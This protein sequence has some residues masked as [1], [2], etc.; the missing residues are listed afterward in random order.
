MTNWCSPGAACSQYSS[1]YRWKCEV[2]VISLVHCCSKQTSSDIIK[3]LPKMAN[4]LMFLQFSGVSN[5]K[6]VDWM[7]S[8]G[9][10]Q[11]LWQKMIDSPGA[12]VEGVLMLRP[13][14]GK[15]RL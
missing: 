12:A 1:L 14:M 7:D 2:L 8:Q 9:E 5:G 3:L 10:E 13:S 11:H 6:E 4:S 15:R